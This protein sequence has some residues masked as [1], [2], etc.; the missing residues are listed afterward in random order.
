MPRKV[1]ELHDEGIYHV[2]NRGNDRRDLFQDEEDFHFFL[3][4]LFLEKTLLGTKLYHY[5]LMTNHFHLLL[6]VKEGNHLSKLMHKTQLAYARYFKKKYGFV[7]HVFQERF[8]SPRIPRESYYLQCGKYIERNPVKAGI[9]KQAWDY[10]YSSAAFYCLGKTDPLVTCNLYYE[11]L[12]QTQ[13]ERQRNYR[14]LLSIDDP[15]ANIV[16]EALV[17]V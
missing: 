7:G 4:R 14:N 11:D 2:F 1:R 5:S 12:G 16:E 8:R 10:L 13:E 6:E 3:N 17:Q 15:Y 9:V